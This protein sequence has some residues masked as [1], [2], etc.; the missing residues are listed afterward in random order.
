MRAAGPVPGFRE[1]TLDDAVPTRRRWLAAGLVALVAVG[2]GAAVSWWGGAVVAAG[3]G[4]TLVD[5]GWT[6]WLLPASRLLLD[7]SAVVTVTLPGSTRLLMTAL[8]GFSVLVV[9]VALIAPVRPPDLL[10]TAALL[11]PAVTMAAWCALRPEAAPVE[12]ASGRA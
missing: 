7:A 11:M 1:L 6:P 4:G 2:S 12:P 9:T 5:T 10:I 8:A 3:W